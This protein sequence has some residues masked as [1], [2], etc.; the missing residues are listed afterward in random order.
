MAFSLEEYQGRLNQVQAAIQARD[1]TGLLVHSPHNICYLTGYHTS[2][3]FAY[4]VLF[5]PAEGEPLLLV[6]EL[7]RTNAD[8]YSWLDRDQQAIY[9]DNEDPVA[10]T[11]RWLADLGWTAAKLPIAVEKSSFNLSVRDYEKLLSHA[12]PN[13]LVDG[14]VIV[15][16]V[17]V[18]KSPQEIAYARRAALIADVG[19]SA[20]LGALAVGK[21]ELEI[22]AIIQDKQI[23]AG[24][25]YTSLPNYISSGYRM[26]IGHATPTEKVIASGDVLKFEITGCVRR[27]GA[28]M[29]R[30][31][32]MG[33]PSDDVARVADLLISSQDRAF[34]MM[35]P[36]A[37]AG[38]ID[39]A[40]RQPVL[41]TGLRN[42][43]HP[44]VGYS[45]GIGFPPVSGEWE[46]REFMA[47]DT[48]LLEAGTIFH[49]IINANGI[50]FSETILVHETGAERLTS[51]DRELYV[52]S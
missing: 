49:M 27:Y 48:W 41:K 18:V 24:C 32:V 20:G 22:A 1:L 7:E 14:S 40:I 31:A 23:L 44:R 43:Y 29:M 38:D 39:A 12:K 2:G 16:R 6:R 34:S 36:G 3:F 26:A 17:R 52:V 47:G 28:A 51:L 8:E 50:S 25:E 33:K 4:Q 46:V 42:T 5:V 21:Q 9:L 19:M 11:G 30:T 13:H 45:L 10:V 15:G 35:K 37:V